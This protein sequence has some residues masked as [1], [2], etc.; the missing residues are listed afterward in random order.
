M[1]LRLILKVKIF[2]LM[3]RSKIGFLIKKYLYINI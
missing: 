1:N 3:V 2:L